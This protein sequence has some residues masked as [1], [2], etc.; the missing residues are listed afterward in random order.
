M[1]RLALVV[2]LAGLVALAPGARTA[3]PVPEIKVVTVDPV[4]DVGKASPVHGVM[5]KHYFTVVGANGGAVSQ[6][7]LRFEFA[8]PAE[9]LQIDVSAD[10]GATNLVLVE[11]A[12]G[13]NATAY[14]FSRSADWLMHTTWVGKAPGIIEETAAMPPGVQVAAGDFIGVSAWMRGNA[15]TG[16]SGTWPEVVVLYRWLDE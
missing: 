16:V 6:D 9:I 8:A 11:F 2:L 5:A 14:D 15:G 13:I 10:I 3:T 12:V 7:E 4:D 1:P